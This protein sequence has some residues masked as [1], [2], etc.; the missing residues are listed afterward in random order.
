MQFLGIYDKNQLPILNDGSEL[1]FT[2]V[3]N[4]TEVIIACDSSED[5]ICSIRNLAILFSGKGDYK[6]YELFT[7]NHSCTN[8]SEAKAYAKNFAAGI[9]KF[10]HYSNTFA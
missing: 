2:E 5:K 10:R 4:G 7:I 6:T 3:G 9:L 8:E 1:L